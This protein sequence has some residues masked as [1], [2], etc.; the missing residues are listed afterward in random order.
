MQSPEEKLKK[1]GLTGN[2]A[3]AY[4]ELLKHNLINGSQLAKK[5]SLDRTLTYQILNNLVE[6]GLVHY[7]I[8]SHKKYFGASNP[9][10]LLN[11]LKE[12]EAFIKDLIPELRSFKK[13]KEEK[14]EINIYEGIEGLRS[15]MREIIK[16]KS[17]CAF[18]ATGRAYDI[19]YELP[20]IGKELTKKGFSARIIMDLKYKTHEILKLKGMEARFLN[21]KGKATTTIFGDKVSIHVIKEKP[22]IIVIK[23]KDIVESY[24]NHFEVLW[25]VAK[26]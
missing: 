22:I 7:I 15:L 20:R 18:G 8:K 13:I 2:E 5:A 23:N 10:N 19:L 1:C 16:K 17:F 3:K 21:I 14:Q 4:V 26:A 11:P 6:K 12:K 9:Q 25:E 24:K